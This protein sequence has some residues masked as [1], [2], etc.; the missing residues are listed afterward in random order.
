MNAPDDDSTDAGGSL[1]SSSFSIGTARLRG[2]VEVRNSGM[3]TA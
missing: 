3:A 2:R 1:P